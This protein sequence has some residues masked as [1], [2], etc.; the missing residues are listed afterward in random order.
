MDKRLDVLLAAVVLVIGLAVVAL[1]RFSFHELEVAHDPIGP[2]GFAYIVGLYLT[3]GA[4]AIL[5]SRVRALRGAD[6][7][8]GPPEETGDDPNHP[9]SARRAVTVMLLATVYLVALGV[10][11]YL[12]ATLPFVYVAL[13]VMRARIRHPLVYAVSYTV[14][15][16]LLFGVAL[17]VRLPTGPPEQALRATGLL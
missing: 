10:V 5:A 16:F 8:S 17:G 11:G 13:R 1:A 15:T 2:R 4:L 9:A 12:V 3:L 14:V 6:D 7:V